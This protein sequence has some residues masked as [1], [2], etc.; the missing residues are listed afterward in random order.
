MRGFEIIKIT[1]QKLHKF[2]FAVNLYK[3][4]TEDHVEEGI[5]ISAQFMNT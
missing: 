1:S 3:K 4:Y 5:F 2:T